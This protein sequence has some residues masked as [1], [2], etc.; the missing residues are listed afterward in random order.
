MKPPNPRGKSKSSTLKTK[1]RQAKAQNKSKERYVYNHE[2]KNEVTYI[3]RR[4]RFLSCKITQNGDHS[5][6]IGAVHHLRFS[7]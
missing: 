2:T 5:L 4:T 1:I 3:Q 6:E 7:I